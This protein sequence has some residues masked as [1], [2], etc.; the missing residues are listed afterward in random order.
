M[1]KL[2]SLALSAVMACGVTAALAGCDGDSNT[3]AKVE[4]FEFK[5]VAASELKV[6]L[7]CLHDDSSTYDKNFIDAMTAA[8]KEKKVEL[9]K[10]LNKA[11]DSSCFDAAEDLVSQGCK[12]IFAD[13]FGH[14][15]Y[16]MQ[17]AAKYPSV[18]FCHATGTKALT[19]NLGNYHNAFASIYEGRYLAGVAAGMKLNTLETKK[20]DAGK[21]Y[22]QIGYVG[23]YPYAEVI[24]GFTSFYLG[25]K[26]VAKA[27]VKMD[28]TYTYSWYSPTDEQAGAQFLIGKGAQLISQHA[29]SMGAPNECEAK[30][31]PNVTYNVSTKG[32][33][34]KTY[35][36]GSR[37]N[38]EPYFEYMIDCV[39][40]GDK[41]DSDWCGDIATNSV[42][43]SGLN[44]GVA[45]E[46]TE[47]KLKE[48]I[49]AFK[50]GTLKVFATDKFTVDGKKLDQYMAD[51]DGDFKGDTNVI[52]DGY[53]DESNAKSFRSAPYF[54]IIIDGVTNL[55][56]EV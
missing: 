2:V 15:S 12:V 40:N 24:S 9:V 16:M 38:W 29:D 45:A 19:H 37:I 1:K 47:A 43:I 3:G 31:I 7:I 32:E 51:I 54:D 35:I 5:P 23:A 44:Q 53:F 13:S 25:V 26:S 18:Q 33:C 22:Y 20:D 30:N 21:A 48:A 50:A 39:I 8:C 34:P 56:K 55:N 46:G 6:G 41:I 4:D 11:E 52:H 28:V 36:A 14:E 10:S 42:V 49:D 27:D 17:A